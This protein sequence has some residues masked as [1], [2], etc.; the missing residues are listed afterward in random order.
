MGYT[1]ETQWGADREGGFPRSEELMKSSR[2]SSS[3]W[4]EFIFM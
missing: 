4:M 2:H 3:S 1:T